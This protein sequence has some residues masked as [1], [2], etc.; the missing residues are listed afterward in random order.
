MTKDY[1]PLFTPFKIG[2][3]E[4][5]NRIVLS[6]MGHN[7]SLPSGAKAES[8]IAYYEERAR[9]GAGMIITGCTNLDPVTAQGSHEG[10]LNTDAGIPSFTALCE[11]VHRWG[12]KIA[13]Q[14]TPGTGRN[15]YPNEFGEPPISSSA[16]PCFF[17]PDVLCRPLTVAEIVE[18][19]DRFTVAAG[20]A[21]D[22]GF[23]AIEVH[24]HAGYLIDQ[25]MSEVFNKRTDAYG[26]CVENR[27]RFAREIV[28]KIK[29]AVPDMPVLF[30]IALDH[31]FEG[32]R[33]FPESRELLKSLEASG[34][35]AFNV[36]AGSYERLDFIFPP[37]YMGPACMEYVCDTARSTVHVPILNGGTHDSDTAL[38]LIESGKADFAV[39]GRA[40][41][42]DPELP[43]KLLNGHRED[44]RPCLRCNEDCIG[45]IWNRRTR[46]SCS[47][48]SRVGYE[49]TFKLVKTA[50][51]KHVVVI[52][53]G[54]AGMEAARVA[55]LEGHKV[56][57]FEKDGQL[58]G[59]AAVIATAS[60]KNY[61]R[62]LIEWYRVQL[63]KLCIEVHLNTT[64][65]A[66]DPILKTCDQI[67][68][69][70]GS[71]PVVPP[72]P[73]AERRQRFFHV[74]RA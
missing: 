5:K 60:F 70:T 44:V 16:T 58:G 36:D 47:V 41:I 56:T 50:A 15:S 45:R 37:S 22:A 12:A 54:P 11:R 40:L 32:G 14:I 30:R 27:T 7:A 59:N 38:A 62:D 17:K 48:N 65:T 39:L 28:A 9:G 49:D 68:V 51:P 6:P 4:V 1:S 66:D 3:M 69:S 24:A 34:I 26:G 33:T 61:I 35:D 73:R 52:G 25:F 23:D 74:R 71:V 2:K 13:L 55:A 67:F 72:H 29:A 31:G 46:F 21:R 63:E 53:G 10:L 64:V 43:N 20:I 57:L 8:E 18:I 42:A 19:E